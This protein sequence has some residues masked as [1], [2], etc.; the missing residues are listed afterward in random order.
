MTRDEF[1]S[2]VRNNNISV[3][4]LWF[5]DII[6]RLKGFSLRVED[7]ERA[8]DEG[9]GFDGSSV[10]GFVRIEESDL[11]ARPDPN[12]FVILPEDF[13][14][15]RTAVM[16]CDILYPDGTPFESDTRLVLKKTVEKARSMGFTH[17]YVGP[18]LEFF[19]FP[20]DSDPTPLD[21]GGYFDILPLDKSVAARKETFSVLRNLG[22]EIEMTH[23][24]V[25]KSQH[26]LDFQYDDALAMADKLQL[27]KVIIKEIARKHGLYA[28]FMP[29]PVFGENGS[30]LHIH[31]S[32]FTEEG[33]AFYNGEDKYNLS[34]VAK[35]YIAGLLTH[36]KEITAVT[37]QWVNS[38]KRLVPGYEAPAYI[39]WGRKNRSALVRV[40][41][42]KPHRKQACRIEYRAPDPACNPYLT[43]SV[44]LAAG[45]E[46]IKNNYKLIDPIELDIYTMSQRERDEKG[47]ESLPD[48]LITAVL[49]M[50]NSKLVKETFGEPLFSKFIAN[51]KSEW[52]RYR[53]RVTDYELKVYFPML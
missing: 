8:L 16:I 32:L 11:L 46:G 21:A 49:E 7:L 17:F 45:L 22:I 48:S 34:E 25:A 5:T 19:Y 13:C 53:V 18:E 44:V 50:E 37:N 35:K 36:C 12:T 24:E 28:S 9:I 15:I 20:S 39:S 40:P 27:A 26:E 52:E 47:I 6:G 41:A 29:K 4:K 38:Y 1:I 51:K 43:F 42:F 33:N 31:Q 30:G 14:G 10:E 3:V 23:H 2:E